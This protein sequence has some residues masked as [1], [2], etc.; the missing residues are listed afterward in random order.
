[1]KN[2]VIDLAGECI[3][4]S[5]Q[6]HLSPDIFAVQSGR[7]QILLINSTSSSFREVVDLS[8][9]R[10]KLPSFPSQ[11]SIAV[12]DDQTVLV[13]WRAIDRNVYL[14][15]CKLGSDKKWTEEIVGL[16]SIYLGL[17]KTS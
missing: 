5:S 17:T 6:C 2:K 8:T 12:P 4:A 3:E 14:I 7:N 13:I 10:K 11:V 1:V 15:T 9:V 16:G